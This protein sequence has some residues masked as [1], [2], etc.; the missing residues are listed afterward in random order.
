MRK[1]RKRKS[2][3]SKTRKYLYIAIFIPVLIIVA[4]GIWLSSVW[5]QI[6]QVVMPENSDVLLQPGLS[7]TDK[8]NIPDVMN[9]LLLGLDSRDVNMR[10]DT[11]ML[12]TLN[13]R[14]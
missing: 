10:S 11:I 7:E 9:I 1:S 5:S 12:M 3:G 14:S 4:S 2:K 8:V 13:R 6:Y